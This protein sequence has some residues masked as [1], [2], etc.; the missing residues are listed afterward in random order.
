MYLN[1]LNRVFLETEIATEVSTKVIACKN[2]N[3]RGI[4][5]IVCRCNRKKGLVQ[6]QGT[7][8]HGNK[9]FC[10]LSELKIKSVKGDFMQW[11]P[12]SDTFQISIDLT[13]GNVKA[14]KFQNLLQHLAGE[15]ERSIKSLPV[16]EGNYQ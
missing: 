9:K 11:R 10:K 3:Q 15:V 1:I 12:I 8:H 2:K 6:A 16:S 14:D 4:R 5:R 13:D 7:H